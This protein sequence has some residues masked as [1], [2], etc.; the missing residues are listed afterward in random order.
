MTV[1]E[2]YC[3]EKKGRKIEL[4][5]SK[6]RDASSTIVFRIP[7]WKKTDGDKKG[8]RFMVDQRQRMLAITGLMVKASLKV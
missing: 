6:K 7:G 2:E 5:K 4:H 3:E 8:V 1:G